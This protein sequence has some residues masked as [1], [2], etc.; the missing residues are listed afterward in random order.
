MNYDVTVVGGGIAGV[1]AALAS[2]RRGKKTALIEKTV[3]LGG[4][5]TSGL[6]Y[7]YLPLCDGNG[8][9]V[10]FGI[11]QELIRL[12]LKYGPGD[13]PANWNSEKN[14]AE[15]NRYRCIFS[16]AAF[17]L[18]LDEVLEEANVEIWLDTLACGAEVDSDERVTGIY[19]ENKSGR[20]LIEAECFIDASGD[21][22]V[23]RRAGVAFETGQNYLSMWALQYNEKLQK[24]DL[25]ENIQMFIDGCPPYGHPGMRSRNGLDGRE[26]SEFIL[27]GRKLLREHYQKEYASGNADRNSLYPL[28]LPAMAQFRKIVA[29]KGRKTLHDNQHTTYFEDSIGLI[30]D[31][32]QPGS[33]W[34]IP[35]GTLVPRKVKGLLAA[36]RCISSFGDAW[37]VTRTI[38][39]AA[40][41]GEVAG[42]AAALSID[43]ATTPDLLD[44]KIVQAQLKKAGFPLHLHDVG[45]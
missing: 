24:R 44:F 38:P 30:A 15:A 27:E 31:W 36:G 19:V 23:A 22:E 37:E 41:T 5:A 13:I 14:A 40:L 6:V 35:Y 16:P 26:V 1:A 43:H 34:E 11:C 25:S 20:G 12:S 17:M 32:R 39:A 42:A 28:K 21:G 45:L 33:V 2:A 18:A 4:L 8:T 3:L 10:T 9:Q 29:I 7:V